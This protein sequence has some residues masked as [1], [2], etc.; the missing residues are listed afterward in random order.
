MILNINFGTKT[1]SGHGGVASG[2][3]AGSVIMG[4]GS[5]DWQIDTRGDIVPSGTF[6]AV[7]SFS[8]NSYGLSL[9]T[10]D[11]V[12]ITML[13][14]AAHVRAINDGGANTDSASSF[15]LQTLLD[16]APRA[17][18]MVLGDIIYCRDGTLA[19]GT[20]LNP[21]GALWRIRP[22][23]ALYA[24][25][26]TV[27]SG[28]SGYVNGTYLQVP[29]SGGSGSG[30][31][32]TI[33][34]GA[35]TVT[36]VVVSAPGNGYLPGDVLTTPAANLGGSG[37]GFSFT[38]INLA[39]RIT[40]QSETEHTS[41]DGNGNVIQGG[42]HQIGSLT[43]DA[44]L[45]GD[46]LFPIDFR[47]IDFFFDGTT[48]H[49]NFL[50]YTSSGYGVSAYNCRFE[51]GSSVTATNTVNGMTL[52]AGVVDHC[53]FKNVGRGITG[54]PSH[55]IAAQ[56]TWNI[57]EA[58]Q[59]DAMTLNGAGL[60]V[61]DNFAFNFQ[62]ATGAHP[63]FCQHLGFTGSVT[64]GGTGYAPG[65]YTNVPLTGGSGTGA[66]ATVTVNSIG[67]VSSCV[68]TTEGT[69][70]TFGDALSANNANLGGSGSG[71]IYTSG[72]HVDGFGSVLRNIA[73]RNVGVA[74]R[75]DAQ[76]LFFGGST[77]TVRISGAILQNNV[78]LLTAANGIALDRFN[79]PVVQFNNVLTDFNSNSGSS[80]IMTL[81]TP[82]GSDG[83][84]GA[85]ERNLV[86]LLSLVTQNPPISNVANKV[87]PRTLTDYQAA[88]PNY[89]DGPNL[90]NRAAVIASMTPGV[91]GTATNADGTYTGALFPDGSWNDGG[92][93][94]PGRL[95]PAA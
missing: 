5:G 94:V 2:A 87:L 75:S 76:G 3:A 31:T 73:V 47:W 83:T 89:T 49:S 63:D 78:L 10:G 44:A 42:G 11:T 85:F 4:T 54:G 53:Y 66:L 39:G 18:A 35:G 70:Y 21:T 17:G 77:G 79:D 28:G 40:V 61:T 43:L 19:G 24:G 74:G 88:L 62:F 64:A 41:I 29:L 36:T 50:A 14:N 15:Q 59:S 20:A 13:P 30:A 86:T 81:S 84:G 8:Q 67:V 58:M 91:G 1:R 69:G 38:V 33:T 93:Y 60:L 56:I 12:N 68:I 71:F 7:K 26:G 9:A 32:A 25:T 55:G 82:S 34:V 65:T 27:T 92:V 16:Q 72:S 52:R 95:P 46:I 37:S 22:P 57:F 23:A 45:T 80:L 48:S 90:T 6:G 51:E